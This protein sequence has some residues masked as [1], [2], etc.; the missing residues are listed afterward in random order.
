MLIDFLMVDMC[1]ESYMRLLALFVGLA[2]SSI[3]FL[4]PA[5]LK[6]LVTLNGA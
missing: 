1:L 6:K 4:S 2:G 3:S 5:L